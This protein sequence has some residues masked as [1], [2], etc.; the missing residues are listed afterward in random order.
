MD[1]RLQ[2]PYPSFKLPRRGHF[3]AARSAKKRSFCYS[4]A[5]DAEFSRE[6]PGVRIRFPPPG[7]LCEPTVGGYRSLPSRSASRSSRCLHHHRH[8]PQGCLAPPVQLC[9]NGAFAAPSRSISSKAKKMR[10]RED[11]VDLSELELQGLVPRSRWTRRGFVA[12]SLVTGFA[13]SSS[14]SPPR[15]SPPTAPDLLRAKSR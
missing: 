5:A 8:R 3:F 4:F 11:T 12:T 10:M 7:N 13:L 2:A 9:E 1:G 6:E 15:R 14:R